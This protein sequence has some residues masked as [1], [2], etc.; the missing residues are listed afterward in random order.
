MKLVYALIVSVAAGACN[1]QQ[2]TP[3]EKLKAVLRDSIGAATNPQVS[4]LNNDKHLL[5]QFDTT[6]F[7]SLSDS[8]FTLR[9]K[10]IGGFSKRHYE[11]PADLDSISVMA[12]EQVQPGVWKIRQMRTFSVSALR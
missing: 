6:A 3:R 10:E 4:Y 9:A 8:V 7:A 12:H 2:Q 5:V 1:N 11:K